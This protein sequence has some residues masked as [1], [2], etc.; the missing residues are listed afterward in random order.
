M[1]RLDKLSGVKNVS[2]IGACIG[3]AFDYRLLAEVTKSDA[4]M[5]ADDLHKLEQSG[6]V[7][8]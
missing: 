5:L 4:A 2:Q 6:L 7:L 3:R 8:P 1:A